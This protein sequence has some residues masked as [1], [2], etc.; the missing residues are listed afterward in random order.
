MSWP[1]EQL[2][3]FMRT[4]KAVIQ[5]AEYCFPMSS[6][7]PIQTT[8]WQFLSNGWHCSCLNSCPFFRTDNLSNSSGRLFFQRIALAVET[9]DFFSEQKTSAV[10]TDDGFFLNRQLQPFERLK[11]FSEQMTQPIQMA[12]DQ[13][14][15]DAKRQVNGN[16]RHA[17][18]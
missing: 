6:I 3:S 11:F 14:W 16:F 12:S 17:N 13:S 8:H 7:I 5:T 15:A 1:I 2:I 18:G 4:E 9:N 10:W